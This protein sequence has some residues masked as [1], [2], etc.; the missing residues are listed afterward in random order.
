ML[1]WVPVGTHTFDKYI[2]PKELKTWSDAAGLNLEETKGMEY[3]VLTKQW[4]LTDD[5]GVNYIMA[6]RLPSHELS[7]SE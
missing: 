3:N 1:G 7:P 5:V 2:T 4:S 6:Y